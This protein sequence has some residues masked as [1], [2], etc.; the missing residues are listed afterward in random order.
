VLADGFAL[1]GC[2]AHTSVHLPARRL[3]GPFADIRWGGR[4]P[5]LLGRQGIDLDR[6]T[7]SAWVGRTCWWL[8]PLYELILSTVLASNKVFA[9][10]T[11]LPVLD[12]GR[13]K[14]KTG[15]LW[16]YAVDDRPWAGATHPAVA[17]VYSEDRKAEHPSAHLAGFNGI[18]Q[19]D[20]YAG[21]GSL[22]KARGNG[23]IR[24]AFCWAHMRRPFYEIYTSNKSPLAALVFP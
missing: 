2:A 18:L 24:L 22:V 4:A 19:V 9:D 11:T 14:T 15:R 10:E 20:G 17:Y 1:K 16:C 23:S 3:S 12:P 13:G 8:A 6:S 21:F 5:G 7:L